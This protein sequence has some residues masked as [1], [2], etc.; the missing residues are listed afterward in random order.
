VNLGMGNKG[1]WRNNDNLGYTL[2]LKPLQQILH[3]NPTAIF[4]FNG[5]LF[6]KANIS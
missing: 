1:K 5:G 6:S 2:F 3:S 4:A